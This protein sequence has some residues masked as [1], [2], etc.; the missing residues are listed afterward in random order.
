M[1]SERTSN[2]G[3]RP[4][5]P[6][7]GRANTAGP[8]HDRASRRAVE[9][10]HAA[11]G[12]LAVGIFVAGLVTFSWYADGLIAHYIHDLAGSRHRQKVMGLALQREAFRHDDLL[13][14]YGSSEVDFLNLYH[15][16]EVFA[17]AP[18]GFSV[19]T[20]GRPG[21]LVFNAMES[22]GAIGADLR[23]KKL[24]VS[25]SPTMFE[26]PNGSEL[27]SRYA[28][29]VFPLQTLTLLLNAHLSR[30][31]RQQIAR[32][33]LARSSTLERNEVLRLTASVIGSSSLPV[34]ALYYAVFPLARLQQ[35]LLEI[36]DKLLELRN[37][38]WLSPSERR[39]A[40]RTRRVPDWPALVADATAKYQ[41]ETTTNPFGLDD[42]WWRLNAGQRVGTP[43]RSSDEQFLRAMWACE[44]WTDLEQLLQILKELD[45]RPL[46]LSMPFHG[47]F[48]EYIGV[49]PAASHRYYAR[50]RELAAQYGARTLTLED[51]ESD[52]YFLRDLGSHLSPVGW[53]FY[54]QAID[55]FFHD[56][57]R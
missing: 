11:A 30:G 5:R 6:G 46:I 10:T 35:R 34:Q 57:L 48:L 21:G 51:H 38:H 37:I 8:H 36:Q 7:A 15:A 40:S 39:V 45:A 23:G 32:R 49:T 54:D 13:P 26:L 18:T 50:V 1:D 25:L 16:R 14:L 2:H 47:L 44:T 28:S 31:L 12:L 9:A 43:N 27:N 55:A 42:E 24:V 33:L 17:E 20:V 19:F 29:N 52:R 3:L 53:V 56:T 22:L 4:D 41:A